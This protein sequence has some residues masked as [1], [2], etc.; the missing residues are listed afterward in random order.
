MNKLKNKENRRFGKSKIVPVRYHLDELEII[1][2]RKKGKD[3]SVYI[4]EKSLE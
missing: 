3:T 2:K 4:R 1:N